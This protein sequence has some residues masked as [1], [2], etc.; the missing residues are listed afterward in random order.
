MNN[1]NY[2]NNQKKLNVRKVLLIVFIIV[3]GISVLIHAMLY[4][5]IVL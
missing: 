5:H 2:Q 1:Y 3:G 4:H